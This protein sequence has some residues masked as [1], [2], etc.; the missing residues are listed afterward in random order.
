MNKMRLRFKRLFKEDNRGVAL[1]LSIIVVSVLFIFTSFLVR[2]V[3]TNTLTVGRAEDE[4]TSYTLAKEGI[5]YAV[6]Q[7]NT[8]NEATDWTP[9]TYSKYKLEIHKDEI[10]SGG[11]GYIG[12]NGYIT[13]ESQDLPKKLITLQG[14]SNYT[15]PLLKYV[16][17]IDS[18]VNFASGQTFGE[19]G[20][21]APTH[22]NGNLTLTGVNNI[23]LD[24]T[25]NDKFEVAGQILASNSSD[26]V[27]ILDEAG[28]ALASLDA[29]AGN[30]VNNG[31]S[32]VYDSGTSGW[33]EEPEKFN[34]VSGRY[35]DSA[36]LPSSY[37][38]SGTSPQ[39]VGGT[40]SLFWPHI[41]EERYS[42]LHNLSVS[43]SQSDCG[44][45][46]TGWDDWYPNS[47]P[48]SSG[49]YWRQDGSTSTSYTY[50]PPGV[51]IVL[52]DQDLDNADGDNDPTTGDKEMILITDN[53]INDDPAEYDSSS[54]SSF[55]TYPVSP[56]IYA[57][58]DARVEGIIPAG[59]QMTV[60][61]GSNIYIAGNIYQGDST[62]SLGLLANK[63]VLFNTTHRWV[64]NSP[65]TNTSITEKDEW[66][67]DAFLEGYIDG[68]KIN[69]SV[70]TSDPTPTKT[71]VIDFGGGTANNAYQTVCTKQILLR[72]CSWTVTSGTIE[73][74][75]WAS[76]DGS[77]WVEMVPI[78]ENGTPPVL[79][80]DTGGSGNIPAYIPSTSSHARI[81]RYIKLT[82]DGG[83]TGE[84]EMKIDSLEV[85]L[86][87]IERGV[88][89]F[90]QEAEWAIIPGNV[91]QSSGLPL[92]FNV[93]LSEKNL[94]DKS[95]WDTEWPNISYTYD[96][97]L[98]NNPPPQLPPSVNLVSL[99]RK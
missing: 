47:F 85:V 15:S 31:F 92:I 60:V 3:V 70:T 14:I 12:K 11:G 40:G 72:G 73:L 80:A 82:L 28:I 89:I 84:G 5:L 38:Y 71:Q 35:F 49:T 37:D 58:G 57:P 77:N 99:G 42:N 30:G 19:V 66:D 6:N 41:D 88:A 45:R 90:S 34:T 36:H 64:V 63:N 96:S 18:D 81:F 44:N 94:E 91:G 75:L 17:F 76:L 93:A 62:S 50:T 10:P 20:K 79:S 39:Y 2:R 16:R 68:D 55:V 74:H 27:T 46:G 7:L 23:Y 52:T 65:T 59:V 54:N 97:D 83:G 51:H 1:I 61:S 69:A 24:T 95:K 86:E 33:I 4:Q 53:S 25:R 9:G 22:I 13:I 21:G 43:I 8:S 98:P 29:V 67:N 32:F 26:T 87:G 56:I 48:P 78:N